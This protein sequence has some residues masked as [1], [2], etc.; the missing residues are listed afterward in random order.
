MAI[1]KWPTPTDREGLRNDVML[2]EMNFVVPKKEAI[3]AKP[4]ADDPAGGP[5]AGAPGSG[6]DDPERE[7]KYTPFGIKVVKPAGWVEKPIDRADKNNAYTAF[8]LDVSDPELNQATVDVIVYRI[9]EN[10]KPDDHLQ[11]T[12]TYFVGAHPEGA[13]EAWPFPT[14][15]P[16]APFLSLPD[17]SKKREVK[18]PEPDDPQASRS[19]LEDW[20]VV[21]DAKNA[22][23][24]KEKARFPWRFCAVGNLPR[25][26]RDVHVHYVFATSTRTYIVRAV[27]R[28][29]G[30]EK[31]GAGA[32]KVLSTLAL[33]EEPK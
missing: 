8:V 2:F 3:G 1:W 12:W 4:T 21:S 14:V 5:S 31:Y 32:Q 23:V 13:L 17:P 33:L 9:T 27:F 30:F 7:I 28:R 20:G 29:D 22:T 10:V 18:R 26:G 11:N 25:V 15:T 19:R 24:G 6:K 16:K